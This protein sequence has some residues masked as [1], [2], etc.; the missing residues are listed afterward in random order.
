MFLVAPNHLSAPLGAGDRVSGGGGLLVCEIFVP[1][2]L[3]MSCHWH[4]GILIKILKNLYY[5]KITCVS[6]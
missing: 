1:G 6:Y 5:L 4:Q 2:C 3:E